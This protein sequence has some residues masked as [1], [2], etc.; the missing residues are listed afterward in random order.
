MKKL[1]L[2]TFLLAA[3]AMNAQTEK[4][5]W[6]IEGDTNL[7]FAGSAVEDEFDNETSI[8]T[9]AFK[10]AVNYFIADNLAVGLGLEFSSTATE[11]N[12]FE[13]T[14]GTFALMP[15]ASYFFGNSKTRPYVGLELGYMST[16]TDND[17]GDEATFTGFGFG[18]NGG[19]AIF[20]S[21]SVSLNIGAAF[22]SASLKEKD[23]DIE[24]DAGGFG[25]TAGFSIF[26]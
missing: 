8:G 18:L 14:S 19:V 10:P 24:M 22:S 7:T 12:D 4:G 13:S 9:F 23:T 15:Q 16:S 6:M 3:F 20:L 17:N 5:T 25:L 11:V 2:L 21:D 26:L 1:F